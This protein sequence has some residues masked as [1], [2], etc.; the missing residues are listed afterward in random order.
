[1]AS[2]TTP[3][4]TSGKLLTVSEVMM[5]CHCS[6]STI[7]RRIGDG[8]LRAVRLGKSRNCAIRIPHSALDEW[9]HREATP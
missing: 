4:P 6:A 3:D 2:V 1:M 9:L 7:R 5:M 8:S